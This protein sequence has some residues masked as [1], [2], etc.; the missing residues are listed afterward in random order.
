M[1]SAKREGRGRKART[2]GKGKGSACYKNRCFCIPP[3]RVPLIQWGIHGRPPLF[4]DH[5]EAGS[6]KKI[7]WRPPRLLMSGSGYARETPLIFWLSIKYV[8]VTLASENTAFFIFFL[9]SAQLTTA[10]LTTLGRWSFF[11]NL[12]SIPFVCD[13]FQVLRTLTFKVR[14]TT[15]NPFRSEIVHI[16]QFTQISKNAQASLVLKERL[17]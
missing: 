11:L 10:D 3:T 16:P 4:L 17:W 12:E 6:R 7:F 9:S 14:P 1:V 13:V 2:R 5:T 8:F 15:M